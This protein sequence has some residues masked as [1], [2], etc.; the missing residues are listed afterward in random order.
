VLEEVFMRI[1]D[2][3]RSGDSCTLV[4]DALV[5]AIGQRM[6]SYSHSWKPSNYNVGDEQTG[7]Y[8]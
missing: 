6:S 4:V 7:V 1:C 8:V 5:I 2:Q 3:E